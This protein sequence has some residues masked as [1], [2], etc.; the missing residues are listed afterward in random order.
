[1]NFN[2]R[3]ATIEDADGMAMVHVTSWQQTYRGLIHP[4]FIMNEPSI[5]VRTCFYPHNAKT[6]LVIETMGKIVGFCGYG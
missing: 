1:M 4:D 6:P 3:K 5:K 2:I